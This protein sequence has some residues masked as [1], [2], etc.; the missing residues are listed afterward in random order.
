VYA[1]RPRDRVSGPAFYVGDAVGQQ[2][3]EPLSLSYRADQGVADQAGL[4]GRG[5]GRQISD[6]ALPKVIPSGGEVAANGLIVRM[7]IGSGVAVFT[8]TNPTSLAAD[9]K[10]YLRF[11]R[12][13]QTRALSQL[14]AN[15]GGEF[16]SDRRLFAPFD[17]I[18]PNVP[19]TGPWRAKYV[20]RIAD[21]N[22]DLHPDPGISP[23]AEA[24]CA[25]NAAGAAWAEVK[26]PGSLEDNGPPLGR[27]QRR[28][29]APQDD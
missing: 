6:D 15:L 4:G 16:Q 2:L 25:A 21:P 5:R 19:L 3:L 12:W 27:G 20:N 22:G 8:Q 23:A 26:A 1:F 18:E 29:R 9:A 7:T 24:L 10:A 28:D 14:V 13:R 17:S 11:S